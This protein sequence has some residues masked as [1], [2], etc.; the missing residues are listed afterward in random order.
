MDLCDLWQEICPWKEAKDRLAQVP[1]FARR[2]RPFG[3]A[4]GGRSGHVWP[5]MRE[6]MSMRTYL[7][8]IAALTL[9]IIA[10]C[11][12]EGGT[13]VPGKA[14][15]FTGTW[16]GT[17]S[18]SGAQTAAGVPFRLDNVNGIDE[19]GAVFGSVDS[20]WVAGAFAGEVDDQGR[21]DGIV[22]NTV[23]GLTW[24]LAL[25]RT[26]DGISIDIHNDELAFTGLG[27]PSAPANGINYKTSITNKTDKAHYVI[28][29]TERLLFD[30]VHAEEQ[31]LLEPGQT[32]TYETG[33]WCTLGW[34]P[35]YKRAFSEV[36]CRG[37]PHG[38]WTRP[39]CRSAN[40]EIRPKADTTYYPIELIKL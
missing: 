30:F 1:R 24:T 35:Y 21:V 3:D 25:A 6:V 22:D 39:C 7:A 8:P 40:W 14:S 33:A 13:P 38:W 11:D 34:R 31:V 19:N 16:S 37:D 9:L 4:E 5:A 29:Y 32:Y 20:T 23:D 10:G 12:S 2:A 36:N 26:D 18:V 15:A 27:S 17:A 28:L